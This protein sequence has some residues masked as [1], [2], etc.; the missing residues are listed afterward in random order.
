MLIKNFFF[1]LT[2]MTQE[3]EFRFN[4]YHIRLRM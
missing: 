4:S 2:K 3:Q 1:D